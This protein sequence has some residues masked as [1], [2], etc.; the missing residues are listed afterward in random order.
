MGHSH[1]TIPL[2]DLLAP[3]KKK[4]PGAQYGVKPA[5]GVGVMVGDYTN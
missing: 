1:A 4:P 5:R 3:G 2:E